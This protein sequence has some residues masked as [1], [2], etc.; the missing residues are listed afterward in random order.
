MENPIFAQIVGTK[1]IRVGGRQLR[2]HNK[3]LW[4]LPEVDGVKTG[5]TKAAGRTLVTSAERDGRRLVA[6]TIGAPDDWN[7]HKALYAEGFEKFSIVSLVQAGQ[8]VGQLPLLGAERRMVSLI[9]AEDFSYPLAQDEHVQ[10]LLSGPEFSYA[11]VVAGEQAG[12][13]Y[14][15]IDEKVVGKISVLFGQTIEMEHEERSWFRRLF[16][17]NND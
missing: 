15:M 13:L 8:C 14:F 12:Y 3:L 2:N 9:A 17:G 1:T 16:G 7:D 5:Y 10:F 6:V 11:P 4:Q